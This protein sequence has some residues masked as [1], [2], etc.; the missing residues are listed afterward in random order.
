VAAMEASLNSTFDRSLGV[1]TTGSERPSDT[2]VNW[3]WEINDVWNAQAAGGDIMTGDNLLHHWTAYVHKEQMVSGFDF[4]ISGGDGFLMANLGALTALRLVPGSDTVSGAGTGDLELEHTDY[5][6]EFS[7][8]FDAGDA[9]AAGDVDGDGQD[10]IVVGSMSRDEI[11]VPYDPPHSG[12]GSSDA[13][14]LDLSA[15]DQI[16]CGQV[17]PG[18]AEEIVVARTHGGGDKIRIYQYENIGV[19]SVTLHDSLDIPFASGDRLAV[20]DVNSASAGDEI[21]VGSSAGSDIHV[22]D[23]SGHQLG[24]IPCDSFGAGD[25]LVAGDLDG[26]GSDEIALMHAAMEVDKHVFV[27]YDSD[28]WA[29]DPNGTW[30]IKRNKSQT[31]RSRFLNFDGATSAGIACR[32]FDGDGKDE[33][34]VAHDAHDRLYVYDAHYPNGWKSRYMPVLQGVDQDAD[35][36][37]L[38]GHGNAGSCSPFSIAEIDTLS[39]DANPLVLALSC[40]TGNYEGNGDD[41]FAEHFVTSGAAVYIGSTEVSALSVSR[42]MGPDFFSRWETGEMPGEVFRDLRRDCLASADT[43]TK[44]WGTEHNFY[45]D[46]KFGGSGAAGVALALSKVSIAAEPTLPGLNEPVAIPDCEIATADGVSRVTIP[47]GGVLLEYARPIVPYYTARWQLPS[48]TVVQD[49]QLRKR[50]GLQMQTGLVL[51][52]ATMMVD[53]NEVEPPV[54]PE[55]GWYPAKDLTWQLI[56]NHDRSTTLVVH[57]YPFFYNSLTTEARFYQQFTIDVVLA[58]SDTRIVSLST[59]KLSYTP[60]ETVTA[61][62]RLY[63][64]GPAQDVVV[65][66]SIRQY[67]SDEVV[68]GLLLRRLGGLTGPASFA[69]AWD[70]K[71]ASPG[72]YCVDAT[73]INAANEVLDRQ[74]YLFEIAAQ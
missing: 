37:V 67:G 44:L 68:A 72:H 34:C 35:L 54:Q 46:P 17:D 31:V 23:S 4:P 42:A 56:Q 15:G 39:F 9:L 49:V 55:P 45:G 62:M 70:S 53:T 20:A 25:A 14:D 60:G 27:T 11:A 10:E 19:P 36:L 40:T 18:G 8:P 12:E 22:Y 28:C 74:R 58:S 65:D 57:L 69:P 50:S 43:Y 5:S 41:S 47:G 59:E 2:F 33:I 66:V 51:P 48:G 13:A 71:G 30:I 6:E 73:L 1:V 21:I 61:D 52:I 16:V 64:G 3:A 24:V 38:C 29:Q 63:G 7:C 26:D 32:D